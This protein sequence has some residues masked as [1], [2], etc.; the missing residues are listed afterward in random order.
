MKHKYKAGDTVILDTKLL[1]KFSGKEYKNC[2]I[3]PSM[4]S[5]LKYTKLFIFT[6][7]NLQSYAGNT[8]ELINLDGWSWPEDALKLVTKKQAFEIKIKNLVI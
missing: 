2:F 5:D 7:K 6:I 8:Y 4:L 1:N 3:N